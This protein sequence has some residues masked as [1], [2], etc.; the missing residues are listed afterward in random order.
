L[1]DDPRKRFVQTTTTFG[2]FAQCAFN[3]QRTIYKHFLQ[4][5]QQFAV[6]AIRASDYFKRR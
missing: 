4:P 5:R 6:Q 1:Q 2:G 3:E